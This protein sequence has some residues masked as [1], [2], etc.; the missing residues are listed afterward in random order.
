MK[1]NSSAQN[2]SKQKEIQNKTVGVKPEI[3]PFTVPAANAELDFEVISE[4]WKFFLSQVSSEKFT[5]GPILSNAELIDYDGSKIELH[6]DSK[7]DENII[8]NYDNY[9]RKKAEEIFGKQIKFQCSPQKPRKKKEKKEPE[10]TQKAEAKNIS[11]KNTKDKKELMID[12]IVNELGG[13]EI[14]R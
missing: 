10:L 3:Q 6:V 1:F 12:M 4:R 9:L 14:K 7:E 5:F 8:N 11:G 13:R 2:F